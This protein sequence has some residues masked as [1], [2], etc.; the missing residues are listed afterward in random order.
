M[1]I[2]T[3]VIPRLEQWQQQGAVGQ[4]KITQWT[5]YVTVAIALLQST[6]LA[7]LFH[8]GGRGP[9]D[10][11]PQI[12]HRFPC[13]LLLQYPKRGLFIEVIGT[14]SFDI[15]PGLQRDFRPRFGRYRTFFNGGETIVRRT[16]GIADP[17]G[18]DL[19]F[20]HAEIAGRPLLKKDMLATAATHPHAVFLHQGVIKSIFCPALPALNNHLQPSSFYCVIT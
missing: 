3:V 17:H 1:Q 2:L 12:F 6:G 14:R 8:N 4:R 10:V 19:R 7:F 13:Q 18:G 11:F 15:G 20:R 16:F 5:R 9:E